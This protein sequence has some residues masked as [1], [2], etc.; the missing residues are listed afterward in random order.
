MA[1][2]RE[3]TAKGDLN[4]Q[5]IEDAARSAS[6]LAGQQEATGERVGRFKEESTRAGSQALR[7]FAG[8]ADQWEKVQAQ[9][10]ISQGGA[11]LMAAKNAKT[12]E[13]N[14]FISGDG[15]D[16][17]DPTLADKFRDNLD[18][19]LTKFQDSFA[20]DS[21]KQWASQQ[22]LSMKQHFFEKTAADMST[23]AGAAAV[24]NHRVMT[25]QAQ[26]M[27]QLDPSALPSTLGLMDRSTE[28]TLES[29]NFTPDQVAKLRTAFQA[30]KE[31]IVVAAG[32][33]MADANPE[34]FKKRL[35]EGW[36]PDYLDSDK[37]KSLDAYADSI[38]NARKVDAKSAEAQQKKALKDAGDAFQNKVMAAGVQGNTYT[39]APDAA[40]ALTKFADQNKGAIDPSEVRAN[41]NFNETAAKAAASGENVIDNPQVVGDMVRR[42]NLPAGS[43]RK[44][45]NLEI[46]E[47]GIS[48]SLNKDTVAKLVSMN[49]TVD[50]NFRQ[51]SDTL[52]TW[53]KTQRSRFVNNMG[54]PDPGGEEAFNQF[55]QQA[56]QTLWSGMEAGKQPVDIAN[57]MT[58]S[59]NEASYYGRYVPSAVASKG[60][61]NGLAYVSPTAPTFGLGTPQPMVQRGGNAAPAHEN[62]VVGDGETPAQALARL[63]GK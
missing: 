31:N 32:R 49:G 43:P 22:V 33:G 30:D 1:E 28:A 58:D 4:A 14:A 37:R 18:E 27:V 12:Q 60:K 57:A 3:F 11:A 62:I 54:I 61:L 16:P 9:R 7:S 6:F 2:I 34:E 26:S 29:G 10:E 48:K 8:A 25:N 19:D 45:T 51:A 5:P 24:N 13:W 55:S 56:Y 52:D 44:L 38:I 42:A 40:E 23:M 15:V 53:L 41:I 20:T 59:R 50:P 47:A 63:K 36:M 17:N 35:A 21:G 46:Y 39:P